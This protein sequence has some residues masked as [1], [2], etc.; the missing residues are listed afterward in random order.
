MSG[1]DEAAAPGRSALT[2]QALFAML[3]LALPLGLASVGHTFDDGDISWHVAVGRW[4]AGHGRIPTADPFSFTAFGHPWV[5]MEWLA[6]LVLAGAFA[7][8]SYAGLATIVAASLMALHAIVFV[9]LR[10]SLGPLGITAAIIA[11]DVMLGVFLLARPHVLVWPLL[12]GWTA[13]LARASETGRPPPLWAALLLALWTNLHGSFPL[14]AVIAAPLCFDALVKAGWTTWKPWLIFAGAS[15]V[16]I[17]LNANGLAGLL[18]PFRVASLSTLHLIQEWQPSTPSATPQFYVVV[19]AGIGALLWAGVRVPPGRLV[20]VLVLLLLAFTQVRHQSWFA[21]VA[22]L[23]VPPLLP[24]RSEP[25]GRLA[26]VALLAIALLAVRA[27]L[28]LTPPESAS[29]PRHLLAAIPA[30]LKTQPV[31]NEY[32][33]GGPL[34]LAGIR[35]Y[36]DGRSEMYGDSFVADYA[37]IAGGDAGRFDRAVMKYNIRWAILPPTNDL[38]VVLDRSNAWKRIY[39]DKV[40][41][42]YVRTD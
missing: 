41:V 20:L 9:H 39:A 17:C 8:A 12:A 24:G 3:V 13:L 42:I 38:V 26:P 37:R 32:S 23:L 33:F 15:A 10:R 34:I 27:M 29:N 14:A 11:L 18:Q 35:P 25:A 5:A 19:L 30:E 6:D 1:G 7:L 2:G 31:F 36:I 21:I 4:I 16:A 40:G 28:P 22:A